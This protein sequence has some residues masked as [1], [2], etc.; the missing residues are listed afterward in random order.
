M[1][2]HAGQAAT[3]RN[4]ARRPD[5][6]TR[7]PGLFLNKHTLFSL[8]FHGLPLPASG[9]TGIS[10]LTLCPEGAPHFPK[11]W[12]CTGLRVGLLSPASLAR[13]PAG[14]EHRGGARGDPRVAGHLLPRP[15][16]RVVHAE[17]GVRG[18]QQP[19]LLP[20]DAGGAA[21]AGV[22]AAQA[23][24]CHL[25]AQRL[26]LAAGSGEAGASSGRS[27]GGLGDGLGAK[28][29][30]LSWLP[31]G[32]C[33]ACGQEASDGACPGDLAAAWSASPGDERQAGRGG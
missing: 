9:G 11:L 24:T 20:A 21:A 17:P 8:R 18:L 32:A 4:A 33:R 13:E 6:A 12:G 3:R 1:W 10:S 15:G 26:L 2:A 7:T 29:L 5:E 19:R 28:S 30:G 22:L 31:P 23:P 16:A 25:L 14:Q 27:V